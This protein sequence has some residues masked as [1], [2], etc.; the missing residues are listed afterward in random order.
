MKKNGFVAT[1]VLY[2]LVAILALVMLII[3]NN[4]STV[5]KTNR[6]EASSIKET[7]YDSASDVIITWRYPEELG[8]SPTYFP[9]SDTGYKVTDVDC[10]PDKGSEER[11]IWNEGKW[12]LEV[13][14]SDINSTT[15][16]RCTVTLG[17]DE[18]SIEEGTS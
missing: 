1:S 12:K 9:Q 15:K 6:E 18:N 13:D 8:A 16:V 17:L 2:S 10:S 14:L 4:Y 7:L 11:G 3:V 5:V